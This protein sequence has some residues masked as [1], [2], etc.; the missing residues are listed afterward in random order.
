MESTIGKKYV[1]SVAKQMAK[2]RQ[3][4]VGINC[5]KDANGKV[6]V[7]N[8]QVKEEWKKYMEKLLNEG[9]TWDNATTCEKVE[10]PCELI[11]SDEISK[12]LRMMKKGKAA[13]PTGIVS[14]MF[15]VDE[16]CSVDWL[17]SLCNLIVAQGRIPDDWKSSILLPV[18]KGKEIQWN[19]DL[20]ER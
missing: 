17:T 3:D 11:R 12:A 16:D 9:N 10:G 2:S 4:L 18:S 20:T 19:V 13:G 5:V 15:M 6:L 8:D 14:E 7:E 1:Y